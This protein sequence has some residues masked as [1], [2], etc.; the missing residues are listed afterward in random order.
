MPEQHGTVVPVSDDGETLVHVDVHVSSEGRDDYGLLAGFG[1]RF[2]ERDESGVEDAIGIITGW[3]AWSTLGADIADAA[4]SISDDAA[5]IG[6]IAS[7]ALAEVQAADPFVEDALLIDRLHIEKGYRGRGLLGK[8]ITALVETLR[9]QVN[10]CVVVTDPEPQREGGG[11]YDEGP[12]RDAAMSGLF[13]SLEAAGFQ[14]W[15]NDKAMW[16]LLADR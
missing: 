9:L 10:G 7:L 8:M 5:H 16:M 13:R 12:Q 3:I 6:Y 1:A 11:Q 15:P 2:Y 4:D 14:S